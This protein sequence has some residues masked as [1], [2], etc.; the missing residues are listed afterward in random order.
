MKTL[1][2][3]N[4]KFDFVYSK[5]AKCY[6]STQYIND[7]EVNFEI[8]EEDYNQSQ[9]DW[10][11]F[12]DFIILTIKKF[13]LKEITEDNAYE[14]ITFKISEIVNQTKDLTAF[15]PK[16]S[17]F[18]FYLGDSERTKKFKWEVSNFL[19]NEIS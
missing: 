19:K 13:S 4:Q 6:M 8:D 14:D 12:V 15:I 17:N 1:Q 11:F 3:D 2:I 10:D 16:F 7:L 9:I 18:T 5:S